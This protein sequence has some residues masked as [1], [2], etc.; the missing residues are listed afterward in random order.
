[1]FSESTNFL[2]LEKL[3]LDRFLYRTNSLHHSS[4]TPYLYFIFD[5]FFVFI[6]NINDEYLL[7]FGIGK[8]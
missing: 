2:R 3:F 1:M 4:L 8:S 7:S 6:F 5:P